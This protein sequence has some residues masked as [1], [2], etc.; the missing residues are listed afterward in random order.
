MKWMHPRFSTP[1]PQMCRRHPR[2]A[3]AVS[4]PMIRDRS[5]T[6]HAT[7]AG[8]LLAVFVLLLAQVAVPA[9]ATWSVSSFSQLQ[10]AITSASPGDLIEVQ[11]GVYPVTVSRL[12]FY[13]G[14]TAAQP[15]TVRGI[16]NG[17]QRPVLDASGQ[18]IDRGIFYIWPGDAWWVFENLEF[19]NCHGGASYSD[20][21]AAAYIRGDHITF[22]N[23]YSHDNDNGWFSTTGS[24]DIL[25]E[26][27]ET[28]FNGTGTGY[29]HNWYM[30]SDSLTLRGCWTHDSVGGINYKDR[31]IHTVLEGNLFENA[32]GYDIDWASNGAG[33]ALMIGNVV[34]RLTTPG[35]HKLINI[36]DG[37]GVRTGTISLI[38]NTL[39]VLDNS[40][41]V[42]ERHGSATA[43]LHLENNLVVGSN[44][45]FSGSSSGWA[46]YPTG[47][48]N[49]WMPQGGSGNVSTFAPGLSGTV[50]GTAPGF[51]NGAAGD[52]RLQAGAPCENAAGAV[53]TWRDGSGQLVVRTPL[54]Q[55]RYPMGNDLRGRPGGLDIGAFE[56]GTVPDVAIAGSASL[57]TGGPA[58][59]GVSG[60]PGDLY[61]LGVDTFGAG[62]SQFFWAAGTLCL[63]PGAAV[64]VT[65][66]I[67]PTG[68]DRL[69]FA[70]DPT[71]TV[72]TTVYVQTLRL[73]AQQGWTFSSSCPTT[74]LTN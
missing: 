23:C 67:G 30:N 33:N 20:N 18:D 51:V 68:I 38:N 26:N 57:G 22:R 6:A 35:N 34:V 56:R 64:P 14:G 40:Y 58:Y 32:G 61:H 21:A 66:T 27:C 53:P 41:R 69:V 4:V 29:T 52:Y 11:P 62:A 1:P 12:S 44:T 17:S 63:S 73:D 43:T 71:F 13:N 7:L 28:A 15:I 49:N 36:G 74:T 24:E 54:Y 55:Y 25:F 42:F 60:A 39:V 19:R 45:L 72:G 70:L 8:L 50:F 31:G 48:S 59:V 9:Q 5:Q 65:K 47:G 3:V 16:M 2:A 37:T 46:S 10:T